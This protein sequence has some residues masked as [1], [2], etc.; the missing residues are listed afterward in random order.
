[1]PAILTCLGLSSH[2]NFCI[3]LAPWFPPD[4]GL[5]KTRTGAWLELG[6]GLMQ[7]GLKGSTAEALL[8]AP[9]EEPACPPGVPLA[10]SMETEEVS[11]PV[12]CFRRFLFGLFLS[13]DLKLP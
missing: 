13:E 9:E 3:N 2:W 12:R 5:R 6:M 1:M 10:E 4:L 11:S 7:N 8:P